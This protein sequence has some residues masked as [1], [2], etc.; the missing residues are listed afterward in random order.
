MTTAPSYLWWKGLKIP[1]VFPKWGDIPY[2]YMRNAVESSWSSPDPSSKVGALITL[3]NLGGATLTSHNVPVVPAAGGRMAE[4]PAYKYAVMEHAETGVLLSAMTLFG[5]RSVG[6]E[7]F[8]P[9]ACCQDCARVIV[10]AGVSM[11]VV[12]GPAMS[13][14]PE[15]WR[16][17][18]ERG[19]ATLAEAN[20]PIYCT[21]E[22]L[23]LTMTIRG[24]E[25]SV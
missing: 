16:S 10:A 23:N 1:P 24:Q 21:T 18:I 11:L 22:P 8:A 19:Y 3:P 7:M 15:D 4:D 9:W 6:A 17:S 2:R 25:V 13:H 20:I 12:H 5:E 14:T